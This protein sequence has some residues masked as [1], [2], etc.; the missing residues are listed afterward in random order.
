MEKNTQIVKRENEFLEK[1]DKR[2]VLLVNDIA[3]LV[4]ASA[5][6]KPQYKSVKIGDQ[7]WMTENLN[8]DRYRNGDLIQE[9]RDPK[10]WSNLKT[11]ACCYC[12][13]DPE[14]GKKYGKLYNWYAVTDPRGL[15][16]EGW[17]IPTKEEFETLLLGNDGNALRK[18]GQGTG[19]GI[20]TNTSGFSAL[21][22]GERRADGD[23]NTT[24]YSSNF[25]S[26]TESNDFP[27]LEA[28]ELYLKDIGYGFQLTQFY[29]EFGYSIR[30]LKN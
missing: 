7:I 24:K 17:H 28:Y 23:F 10:E 21:I 12:N 29:K 14:N 27:E 18:I 26:S 2:P 4:N 1:I 22:A 19:D 13:N 25:W 5:L 9:V 15:A 30:C 3:K 8:I 6:I 16:P 20:G 11:G